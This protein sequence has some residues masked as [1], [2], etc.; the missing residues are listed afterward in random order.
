MT[1]P[2]YKS[3]RTVGS[4]LPIPS[5]VAEVFA[6]KVISKGR[7]DGQSAFRHVIQKHVLS[8]VFVYRLSGVLDSTLV[9]TY[10]PNII[11]SRYFIFCMDVNMLVSKYLLAQQSP[12]NVINHHI[13]VAL[14]I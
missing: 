5:R 8:L 4:A 11:P 13:C 14:H 6:A 9:I 7:N 2:A 3:W 10:L 1:T 12:S